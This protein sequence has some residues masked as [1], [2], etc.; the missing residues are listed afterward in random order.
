MFGLGWCDLDVAYEMFGGCFEHLLGFIIP[1]VEAVNAVD[2]TGIN[3]VHLE[4]GCQVLGEKAVFVEGVES[5]KPLG[6][7]GF[8]FRDIPRA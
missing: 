5:G 6:D 8:N 3:H 7:K 4:V 1:C 2:R